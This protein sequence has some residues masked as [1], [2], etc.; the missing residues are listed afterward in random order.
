MNP[1]N[2]DRGTTLPE[3]LIALALM[4]MV[5]A[6]LFSVYWVGNNAFERQSSGSDAQYCARTAMQW[7]IGDI[8]CSYPAEGD[9]GL[10]DYELTIRVMKDDE[11][12]SEGCH[13]FLSRTNLRRNNLVVAENITY[14]NFTRK[15]G[16]NLVKVTIEAGVNGQS[17]QLVSAAMPRV[18]ST[19]IQ[20]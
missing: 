14:L 18:T 20:N 7:I 11:E 9:T 8:I 1:E 10:D 16:S 6:G 13:Y 3:L 12:E 2:N 5:M 15:S 19:G 4:S 17:Y